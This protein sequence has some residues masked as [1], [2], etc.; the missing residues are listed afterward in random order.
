MSLWRPVPLVAARP[1]IPDE[2][3]T[4]WRFADVES[5]PELSRDPKVRIPAE[6]KIPMG[7]CVKLDG[8]PADSIVYDARRLDDIAPALIDMQQKTPISIL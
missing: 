2:P 7:L 6:L 3:S 4:L 8:R 1:G 5:W